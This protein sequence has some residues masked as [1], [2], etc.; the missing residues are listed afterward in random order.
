MSCI[1][2]FFKCGFTDNNDSFAE[3]FC[4]KQISFL[5]AKV[6]DLDLELKS[7]KIAHDLEIKRIEDKLTQQISILTTKID[8][9]AILVAS[10]NSS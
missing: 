4:E 8:N 2:N 1:K 5:R 3:R 6:I 9:L 10:K 7:L